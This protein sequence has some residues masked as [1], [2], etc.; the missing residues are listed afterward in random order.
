MQSAAIVPDK[1]IAWLP[2]MVVNVF[3]L[4]DMVEQIFQQLGALRRVHIK[5]VISH[6]PVNEQRFATGFGMGPD[7]WVHGA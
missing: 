4:L 3:T 7:N 5:V 1:E 2:S 6:Q